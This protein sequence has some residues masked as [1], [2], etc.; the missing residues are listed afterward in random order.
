[1]S[2]VSVPA[3]LRRGHHQLSAPSQP[4]AGGFCALPQPE[5]QRL[6]QGAQHVCALGARALAEL[7]IEVGA[8]GA[9]LAAILTKLDAWRTRMP[10]AIAAAHG[11]DR[12]P[13]RPLQV[14]R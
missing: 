5:A 13:A 14:V 2:H 11:G 3:T 8:E 4:G 10:V 6:R 7:L 12:F 9:D 1:M